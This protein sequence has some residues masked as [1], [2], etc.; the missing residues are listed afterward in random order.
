MSMNDTSQVI[1]Y[2]STIFVE[3]IIQKIILGGLLSG[4]SIFT[5]CGNLLVLYAIQT[6]KYL[7]TVSN[8]FI[9]SLAIADLAV[10]LFVMPLSSAT[11]ITGRWPF[12]SVICKMWL[13]ID[14]VASTASIFNLVLLSL[15]RYWAVVYPLRYLQQRTRSRATIFILIIWFVA[16]LWAPA[17][18]FWSYIAPKHSDIIN[19]DECD[20]S[21]RLN[22][23]FKTLTALVNFYV[24]L[25]TMIIISCRIMVAIRSRSNMEFGRRI[26][27]ATQKQMKSDRTHAATISRNDNDTIQKLDE[28]NIQ[29][30]ATIIAASS[31]D[32]SDCQENQ[33]DDISEP[34]QCLCSTCKSVGKEE[35]ENLW[36]LQKKP[37]LPSL[38]QCYSDRPMKPTAMIPRKTATFSIEKDDNSR[39]KDPHQVSAQNHVNNF[40]HVSN[41]VEYAD[42]IDRSK[43][44]LSSNRKNQSRQRT[45]SIGST[46]SSEQ[47]SGA[48]SSRFSRNLVKNKLTL[49]KSFSDQ[50]LPTEAHLKIPSA[51]D[52]SS[53]SSINGRSSTNTSPL[54][55]T[56]INFFNALL[57]PS[58]SN[59]LQKELK[60]ARQLGMLVGVF[61]ITWLPYFILFLVV[62]W[63]NHC[64]SE[65]VFT[66]S[67]WLGYLNSAI[68]PLIY[69]L[70]NAH[71]RRAFQKICY[72]KHA[73][74]QLPNLNALRELHALH[75][76][77]RQ[78]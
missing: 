52:K 42:L 39:N 2:N 36:Q 74:T 15:D 12:S 23:T 48:K 51:N 28:T 63:C 60:A 45:F 43:E 72:C 16:L 22:K 38:R 78:R 66:A 24:P 25:L 40:V 33:F 13:S 31:L 68:N 9:L 64:I 77:R 57:N 55:T 6:E 71:F 76:R 37:M 61:T 34:G 10:G 73:K 50:S 41:H 56:K 70:C 75:A 46:S 58:R 17:V 49:S 62:A 59:S 69:P 11:V 5:V 44:E 35:H 65:K 8:L 20:T 53:F 19:H 54:R 47:S 67:I 21:F 26:S 32:P 14:Y 1:S 4:L 7:R 18:I 29:A 3:K 30:I 27:S